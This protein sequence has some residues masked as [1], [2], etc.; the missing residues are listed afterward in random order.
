MAVLST[1][2]KHQI[3]MKEKITALFKDDDENKVK[4][5]VNIYQ[6]GDM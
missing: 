4:E 3:P 2:L 6:I 5:I 1:D